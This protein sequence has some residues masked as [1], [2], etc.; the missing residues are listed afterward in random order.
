[1]NENMSDLIISVSGLRGVVGETLTPAVAMSYAAAFAGMLPAGGV[2]ITRDSRASGS[3]FAD[4]IHAALNAVGRNT[5]DAGITATPTTGILVRQLSAAG[6]IQISAS[7]NPSE[8]NGMKLFSSE[9]RVVTRE[10]GEN[11]LRRYNEGKLNWKD[12]ESIGKRIECKNTI[13]EHQKAIIE[14]IN[15]NAIAERKFRVLLDANHGAGALLGAWLFDELECD[16]TIVG[17]EPTGH[18]LHSPEPTREN[19]SRICDVVKCG[20]FDVA[21]CQDPDADRVAVI[22]ELGR[23][24]GEELTVAISLEHILRVA[25]GEYN[26][27]VDLSGAQSPCPFKREKGA[28]VINCATSRVNEDIAKRYNVPIYRSAVGEANVVDLMLKTGAVFGGEGNGG[29]IDP[30]VGLVRDSFVGMVQILDAMALSGKKISEIANNLPQY[31]LVKRK[32]NIDSSKV[33]LL[34]DKV[35]ESF[36]SLSC[37]RLDGLRIDHGNAWVLLRGSNTEPIIR[38]FAESSDEKRSNELC[39]EIE[40]LI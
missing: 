4:A 25:G 7:H 1:M 21:F 39:D 28:V 11:V 3:M 17:E 29:P 37:D 2:V 14:T 33:P 9:G 18:F 20:K 16:V 40:N 22:D 5:F 34:L 13:T 35:A 26:L 12:S 36:K 27:D 38:I 23:Y 24:I 10:I 8:F 6:G 32:V 31:S 19:L 30:A 15:L